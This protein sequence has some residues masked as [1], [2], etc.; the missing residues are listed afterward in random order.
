[1]LYKQMKRGWLLVAV[2]KTKLVFGD[3]QIK[4]MSKN[5]DEQYEI[6]IV[7]WYFRNAFLI[8]MKNT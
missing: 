8:I 2:A 4:Y 3:L 1:M 6:V 5:I 7:N